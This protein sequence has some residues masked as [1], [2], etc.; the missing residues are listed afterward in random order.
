MEPQQP[1]YNEVADQVGLHGAIADSNARTQQT[2]Q[3]QYHIEEQEKNLAEAQLECRETL[4][5][6]YHLL[7]QDVLRPT[8]EGLMDWFPVDDPKK[9]ILT[10]EGVDKSMQVMKSYINKE[11]LLSNFNDKQ[12]PVRMLKFCLALNANLFMKYEVYFRVPT[13][14]ECQDILKLRISDK[15]KMKKMAYEITDQDFNEEEIKQVILKELEGQ[16]EYEL[17]KIKAEQIK[18]NLR[19]YELIFTQLEALVDA[20]HNRAWKGEERGSLRR[21]FNISEVIGGRPPGGQ[22]SSGWF[23]LGGNKN[24]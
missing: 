15:I 8:T 4:V 5:E 24:K 6:L 9:R 16:I 20:T 11:T 19:E 12:I 14:Q 18:V 10:D 17:N 21:H 3:M 13:L 7:R 23:G 1:A 22:Q 2:Q